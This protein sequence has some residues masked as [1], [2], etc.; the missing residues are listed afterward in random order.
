MYETTWGNLSGSI[1]N[2]N[3]TSGSILGRPFTDISTGSSNTT[4]YYLWIEKL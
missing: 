4:K 3:I 2:I 1:M